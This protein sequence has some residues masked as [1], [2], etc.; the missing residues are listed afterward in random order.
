MLG[1]DGGGG[2]DNIDCFF[3]VY[4]DGDDNDDNDVNWRSIGC[5]VLSSVTLIWV[6]HWCM[7]LPSP[8]R[9]CCY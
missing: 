1:N 7:M 4:D 6:Y 3:S 8:R 5:G 2:D 9:C